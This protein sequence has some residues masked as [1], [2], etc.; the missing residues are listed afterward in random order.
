MYPIDIVQPM[1]EELTEHGFRELLTAQD[2]ENMITQSG[3]SFVVINSVCGCSARGARPGAVAAL[4][5]A[6]KKPKHAYTTF[7]GYDTQAV[8]VLREKLKPY[9]PS[10]PS[11]AIFKE[12][13]LVHFL[14]RHHIEGS[15]AEMIAANL[16]Q[17][18]E[19]HC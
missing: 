6:I 16:I 10:S 2:V 17:A 13:K 3:T 9:P 18:F 1:K 12:G 19:E 11:M 7:A 8:Q 5:K 4:A 14:E 15:S